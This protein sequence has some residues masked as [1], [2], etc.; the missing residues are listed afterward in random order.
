ML[1]KTILTNL[2]HFSIYHRLEELLQKTVHGESTQEEYEFLCQSYKGDFDNQQLQLHL[3]TLQAIFPED[4]K[5]ATL[6]INDM[7]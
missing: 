4:A 2:V 5:S 6:C 1:F 3:E 7:K